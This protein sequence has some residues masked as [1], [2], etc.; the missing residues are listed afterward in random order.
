M[1]SESGSPTQFLSHLSILAN[2][3]VTIVMR[4]VISSWLQINI[5][6]M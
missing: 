3:D 1:A 5:T 4:A 2:Y 6:A